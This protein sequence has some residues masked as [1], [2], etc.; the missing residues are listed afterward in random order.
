MSWGGLLLHYGRYRLTAPGGGQCVSYILCGLFPAAQGRPPL[1]CGGP[2]P[3]PMVLVA[4]P[5]GERGGRG[6][7]GAGRD[8]VA[9]SGA[10]GGGAE[11]LGQPADSG[12]YNG[13]AVGER[14]GDG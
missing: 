11:R 5:V 3:V 12:S 8:P 4:Q 1:L 7:G 9:G 14:F 10:I 6:S 2:E 13:Q